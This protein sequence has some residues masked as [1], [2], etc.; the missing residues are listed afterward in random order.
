MSEGEVKAS[1]ARVPI[2][3]SRYHANVKS[4]TVSS[5]DSTFGCRLHSVQQFPAIPV[6]RRCFDSLDKNVLFVAVGSD[7]GYI[8][9]GADGI[10]LKRV[11][12]AGGFA[13]L[14]SAVA[15]FGSEADVVLKVSN[16]ESAKVE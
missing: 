14:E 7:A 1:G 10:N 12:G 5:D 6:G 9:G 3:V 8:S 16:H 13:Q 11:R 2:S 4:L 15:S